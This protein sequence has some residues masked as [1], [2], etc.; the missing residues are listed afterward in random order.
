M[1]DEP[2]W[3]RGGEEKKPT[4]S[5][6]SGSPK[7]AAAPPESTENSGGWFRGTETRRIEKSAGW[8]RGAQ[9]GM[10]R[11]EAEELRK[12]ADVTADRD[13]DEQPNDL[14]NASTVKLELNQTAKN[15]AAVQLAAPDVRSEQ[16]FAPLL[17]SSPLR[18]VDLTVE[19]SFRLAEQFIRD[20]RVGRCIRVHLQ[21]DQTRRVEMLADSDMIKALQQ[22][23]GLITMMFHMSVPDSEA[24]H[25]MA[26]GGSLLFS[27]VTVIKLW[28]F[29]RYYF[30][31]KPWQKAEVLLVF[32][33]SLI[34]LVNFILNWRGTEI[35][36]GWYELMIPIIMVAWSRTMRHTL[37]V[38]VATFSAAAPAI[39][40]ML[41][42]LLIF[43]YYGVIFFEFDFQAAE[44]EME[45]DRYDNLYF[46]FVASFCLFTTENYPAIQVTAWQSNK[47]SLLYF[48]PF[49]FLT[50]IIQ[51]FVLGRVDEAFTRA[52]K[53]S[54]RWHFSKELRGYAFAFLA[55]TLPMQTQRDSMLYRSRAGSE[56][57]PQSQEE[58]EEMQR[59]EPPEPSISPLQWRHLVRFFAGSEQKAKDFAAV[60]FYF[61]DEDASGDI[62]LLE[63]MSLAEL[64]KFE[65]TEEV[66]LLKTK[67]RSRPGWG[68]FR[69]WSDTATFVSLSAA[70]IVFTTIFLV[71][72]T[73]TSRED[74]NDNSN[75]MSESNMG[76]ITTV[77]LLLFLFEVIVRVLS[78]GMRHQFSPHNVFDF[79][80]TIILLAGTIL[81]LL[82]GWRGASLLVMRCFCL[83]RW[84]MWRQDSLL[85]WFDQL[86]LAVLGSSI[87]SNIRVFSRQFARTWERTSA[88]FLYTGGLLFLVQYFFSV[89]GTMIIDD[90]LAAI[91]QNDNAPMNGAYGE[92]TNFSTMGSSMVAMFQV[93]LTNNWNDLLYT[94]VAATHSWIAMFFI[95]YYILV[96]LLFLNIFTSVVLQCFREETRE[97]HSGN[98]PLVIEMDGKLYRLER[99]GY[100]RGLELHMDLQDETKKELTEDIINDGVFETSV[101]SG[102]E[103]ELL[104]ERQAY[105]ILQLRHE[106]QKELIKNEQDFA[107]SAF[108]NSA[109]SNNVNDF[110]AT[111]DHVGR[112]RSDTVARHRGV[113]T[114]FGHQENDGF[115]V[116]CPAEAQ[117]S[118]PKDS[119]RA[120]SSTLG[121]RPLDLH[122]M[123]SLR[124]RD[125]HLMSLNGAAD[126]WRQ[127]QNRVIDE[128]QAA[129]INRVFSGNVRVH[130]AG[131][132]PQGSR[133]RASVGH[134]QAREQRRQMEMKALAEMHGEAPVGSTGQHTINR[135]ASQ[136][137]SRQT[138]A[139]SHEDYVEFEDSTVSNSLSPSEKFSIEM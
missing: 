84:S 98:Q 28:A 19:D 1:A 107:H 18:Q 66:D 110:A 25:F 60:T 133:R 126:E 87:R 20:G 85:W 93:M 11:S 50:L 80:E 79:Y 102:V 97:G 83:L 125:V 134:S 77:L 17:E 45:Q 10:L 129:A 138:L 46:A 3:F 72:P 2:G 22:I 48:M 52:L 101:L 113:R 120:R 42:I 27:T 114:K 96:P 137:S 82:Y 38:V 14:L 89:L 15:R 136:L 116:S 39:F 88:L 76:W 132:L 94:S 44:G 6:F 108:S 100:R 128:D 59:E 43:G 111:H 121:T 91:N 73:L 51:A 86:T 63:F 4:E 31:G 12:S 68:M 23:V 123:P 47:L 75:R 99:T 109:F 35:N 41:C 131:V 81:K 36:P 130:P 117:T 78:R 92:L 104:N 13:E 74:V 30:K 7:S 69:G 124:L 54:A 49:I 34:V 5:W 90:K 40:S 70:N 56:D 55:I 16:I 115:N 9:K 103:S 95:I 118:N 58:Q 135:N 26:L 139:P 122:Q 64:L 61:R 112:V 29:G 119:P 127:S 37:Q 67:S 8:F 21:D 32:S 65:I 57:S 33:H 105:A 53:Y 71:H 106:K 62:S 24:V